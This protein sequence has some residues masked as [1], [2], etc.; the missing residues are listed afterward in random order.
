MV[1]RARSWEIYMNVFHLNLKIVANKTLMLVG[2]AR[3]GSDT[4]PDTRG[5]WG[6]EFRKGRDLSTRGIGLH[7]HGR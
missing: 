6:I 5:I 3:A 4:V 2:R 7:V 1:P